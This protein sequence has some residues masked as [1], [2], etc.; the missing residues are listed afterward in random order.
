MN[1]LIKQKDTIVINFHI[2]LRT[3]KKV[4]HNIKFF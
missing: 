4:L 2:Y 1:T 3:I